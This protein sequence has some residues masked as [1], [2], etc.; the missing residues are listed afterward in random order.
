MPVVLLNIRLVTKTC[1]GATSFAYSIHVSV[2]LALNGHRVSLESKLR[3]ALFC[4]AGFNQTA[5]KAIRKQAKASLSEN[6]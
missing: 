5:A 4:F 6:N 2:D 1:G 3:T